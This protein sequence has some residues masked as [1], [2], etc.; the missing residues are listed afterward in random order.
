MIGGDFLDRFNKKM[1]RL[2]S[3]FALTTV[4]CVLV[5]VAVCGF[6]LWGF[7]SL[8]AGTVVN[9]VTSML[10]GGLAGS[11]TALTVGTFMSA[12][13]KKRQK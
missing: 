8:N 9:V 1:D 3:S 7:A 12:L 10:I 11:V 2:T 4:V 6:V 5:M 13:E